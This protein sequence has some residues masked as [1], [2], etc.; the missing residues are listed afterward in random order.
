M[1][2]FN[3]FR[4][5]LSTILFLC[6]IY[7]TNAQEEVRPYFT[8]EEMPDM[9]LFLP[10]PPD[11]TSTAFAYDVTQY[12]WGKTQRFNPERSSLAVDDADCSLEG[13]IHAFSD[14]FGMPISFKD[15]PEIY[16]LLRDATIT[17]ESICHKP[18]SFYLRKRPFM[19]FN[20]R[21]LTPNNEEGLAQNG[22]YPSGHAIYGWC[23]ALLLSEINPECTEKLMARAFTYGESRVIVGAHWQSDVDAG[24]LVSSVAY[25]KLHTNQDFLEQMTKARSEF[26]EKKKNG[27][28]SVQKLENNSKEKDGKIYNLEGYQ[29]TNKT[30]NGIYI[31]SGRKYLVK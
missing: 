11:T 12:M 30:P 7:I 29:L 14:S 24:R 21:T 17:C 18:K 4:Y 28:Y 23:T 10:S 25:M 6:S 2:A 1:K 15:T 26:A 9:L 19:V 5:V 20:E 22:S 31:E 27:M 3:S 8:E 16:R 13:L